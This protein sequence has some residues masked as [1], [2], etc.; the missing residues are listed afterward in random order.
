M[1]DTE[2]GKYYLGG[3]YDGGIQPMEDTK[4]TLL[5]A[6]ITFEDGQSSLE[7]TKLMKEEGE[8]TIST[9][10]NT[11][12]WAHGEDNSMSTYHG[13]NRSPIDID[14]LGTGIGNTVTKVETS[15]SSI[16]NTVTTLS[17]MNANDTIVIADTAAT[18]K[19]EDGVP[20]CPP[21]QSLMFIYVSIG[22]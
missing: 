10:L 17:S 19:N 15:T 2:P 3:K 1:A 16:D 20:P 18:S 4:Q 12:L 11:F 21:G 14:L 7:F 6:K 5:N 8:I 9:G 22:L 13:N